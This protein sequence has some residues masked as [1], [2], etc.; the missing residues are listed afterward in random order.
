MGNTSSYKFAATNKE[1]TCVWCGRKLQHEQTYTTSV[2]DLPDGQRTVV[3]GA[4]V[5]RNELPGWEGSG[6]FCRLR[7]AA[8]F[9]LYMAK[10]GRRFEPVKD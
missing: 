8:L 9:G 10:N 1:G 4:K 7:C 3:V 5:N 6:L 2:Q